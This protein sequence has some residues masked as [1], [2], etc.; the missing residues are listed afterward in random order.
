MKASIVD[1]LGL[2]GVNTDDPDEVA[3]WIKTLSLPDNQKA[4]LI[5]M[6]ETESGRVVTDT[7]KQGQ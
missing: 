4:Q 3:C 2:A 5:D 1:M 6:Y 7:Q